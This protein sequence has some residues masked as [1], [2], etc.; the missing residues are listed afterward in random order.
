MHDHQTINLPLPPPCTHRFSYRDLANLAWA[1]A[2]LDITPPPEWVQALCAAA[3]DRVTAASADASGVAG[4]MYALAR[5]RSVANPLPDAFL[6]SLFQKSA[7]PSA[8]NRCVRGVR[9][10]NARK[11]LSPLN[12]K[13]QSGCIAEVIFPPV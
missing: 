1:V 11:C 8:L 3:S 13:I 6:H 12:K 5:W 10:G 4:L 7:P 2:N 9:E